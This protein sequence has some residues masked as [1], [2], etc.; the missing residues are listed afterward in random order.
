MDWWNGL[1]EADRRHWM[2]AAGNTGRASDAW[3]AYKRTERE[4]SSETFALRVVGDSMEPDFREGDVIVVDPLRQPRP[5][6]FVVALTN[7]SGTAMFKQYRD[8]G[9]D[10]RG[11]RVFELFSLN[12]FYP[13]WRSDREAIGIIGTV[14]QHQRNFK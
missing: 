1:N 9:I 11:K 14:I 4:P 12:E 10:E 8:L 3:D 13:P 7:S 5:G 2:E 6:S